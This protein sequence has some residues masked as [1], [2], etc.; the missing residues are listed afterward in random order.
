MN[1]MTK[2]NHIK[3]NGFQ[4]WG[5]V[6]DAIL[7]TAWRNLQS[8]FATKCP[9]LWSKCGTSFSLEKTIKNLKNMPTPKKNIKNRVHFWVR[10]C[11]SSSGSGGGRRGIRGSNLESIYQDEINCLK[12]S[13]FMIFVLCQALDKQFTHLYNQ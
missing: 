1:I 8:G 9:I 3:K 2:D 12:S 5:R 6:C 11:G 10:K 13:I 4:F 7:D